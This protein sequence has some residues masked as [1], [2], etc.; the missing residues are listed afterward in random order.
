MCVST[1]IYVGT[2]LPIISALGCVAMSVVSSMGLLAMRLGGNKEERG[3]GGR[4]KGREGG[5]EG[6]RKGGREGKEGGREGRKEE[7]VRS[8]WKIG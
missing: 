4:K 2:Y 7:G 6:G 8:E 1:Y 5:R 3:E